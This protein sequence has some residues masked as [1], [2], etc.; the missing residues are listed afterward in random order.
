[1]NLQGLLG[2]EPIKAVLNSHPFHA[3][4][5]EGPE[6]SGKHTLADL[7]TNALVC[8][9]DT[10]PCGVCRQCYKFREKCHPD[11]FDVPSDISADAMRGI[12]AEMALVPNDAAHRVYRIEGA[13][14]LH[15]TVQNLLLKTLEEPPSYAVFLLLCNA[16]EGVLQTVR[17]RCQ[18]LTMS[19]LR[20]DL[21]EDYFCRTYGTYGE[22]EQA[23]VALSAGFLGR[24]LTLY[25][26][27]GGET[28]KACRQLEEA[29]LKGDTAQVFRIL[30]FEERGE[31]AAFHGAFSLHMKRQLRNCDKSRLPLYGEIVRLWDGAGEALQ[32]NVN[33]KFW[34]TNLARLCLSARERA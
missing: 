23:A 29:L 25:E 8:E 33:V 31:L 24:A 27:G 4:L 13:E 7:I 17:S 28:A 26:N 11:I 1:M 20:E 9:G 18:T 14:R 30:S 12:L 5:I 21:M 19:P 32:T 15:P 6:G 22:K 3:Y 16:K 34:S 10:P 2:N